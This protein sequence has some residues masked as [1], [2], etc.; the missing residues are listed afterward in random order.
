MKIAEKVLNSTKIVKKITR[1]TNFS[2]PASA[3]YFHFQ[4][5]SLHSMYTF[6]NLSKV[7]LLEKFEKLT[8]QTQGCLA[9]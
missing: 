4:S 5:I 1:S 9:A 3:L 6:G 7:V 8:I 2:Y